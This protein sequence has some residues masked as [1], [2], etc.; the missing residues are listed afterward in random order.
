M[1]TMMDTKPSTVSRILRMFGAEPAS[2]A[3][4]MAQ[5]DDDRVAGAAEIESKRVERREGFFFTWQYPGQW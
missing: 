5:R 3:K 4:P 2:D 1:E